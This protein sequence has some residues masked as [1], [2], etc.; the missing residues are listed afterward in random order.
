MILHLMHY[1]YLTPREPYVRLRV[2]TYVNPA[3]K[4]WRAGWTKP[5]PR[6]YL[7]LLYRGS[8]ADK[9]VTVLAQIP[10]V[11]RL[12]VPSTPAIWIQIHWPT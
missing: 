11:K 6:Y 2:R 1:F 7:L 12:L 3:Q 4:T 8:Y 5:S 10:Y 9:R